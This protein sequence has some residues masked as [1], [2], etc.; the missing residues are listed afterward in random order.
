VCCNWQNEGFTIAAFHS[1]TYPRAASGLESRKK[2]LK[3]CP[4]SD[5]GFF[6][7]ITKFTTANSVII[8]NVRTDAEGCVISRIPLATV[9]ASNP[10]ALFR[11]PSDGNYPLL[12]ADFGSDDPSEITDDE[13]ALRQQI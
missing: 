8:N 12:G 3:S 10:E 5:R 6:L 7:Q 13:P 1:C 11:K 9:T 2:A 4:S